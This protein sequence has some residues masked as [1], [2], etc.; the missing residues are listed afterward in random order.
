MTTTQSPRMRASDADRDAVL[1]QL[2][3]N[4]QAGRLTS[5]ELEERTGHAL[6]A[7][8]LGDLQT[9]MTDLPG[10]AP[11]PGPGPAPAPGLAPARI[12][13]PVLPLAIVALVAVS[14]VATVAGGGHGH[15]AWD[16]WWVLP[17]ALLAR[18][19]IAGRRF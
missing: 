2:S 9:L 8:T 11:A 13:R 7:K 19:F 6:A 14:V 10:S 16:L 12:S 15:H 18:R 3:E 1:T 4:Y 17:V 5:D